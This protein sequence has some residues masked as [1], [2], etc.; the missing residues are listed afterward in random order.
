MFMYCP[1]CGMTIPEG[2]LYCPAC[3]H[4]M[5]GTD[6]SNRPVR[7]IGFGEAVGNFFTQYA[8]F[9][10]RAT[11]SEYWFMV[12]F[13]IL[14]SIVIT[15]IGSLISP[16]VTSILSGLYSL[17]TLIPGLAVIWRR[18]HDAGR[19]GGWFFICLVPV[20]GF[21]ILLVFLLTDSK[22]D[23]RFGPRKV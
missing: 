7:K 14:V 17:A 18:L 22:P 16:E 1:K 3:D 2:T 13:N 10:G 23:N 5:G 15:V 20:V 9:S 4:Y 6:T 21:I 8:T 19:S 11:R 12:L